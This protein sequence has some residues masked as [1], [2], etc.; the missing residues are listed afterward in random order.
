MDLKRLV[1]AAGVVLAGLSVTGFAGESGHAIPD[2]YTLAYHQDFEGPNP[3]S[4]FV[5]TDP[6]AWTVKETDGN[7][8]LALSAASDYKPPHRSPRNIALLAGYQFGSFVMEAQVQYTG[9]DYGHADQC[10]FFNVQDPAH[11]YYTHIGK[12]QDPHAHQIF[13]VD[14]KPRK[15]ITSQSHTTGFPWQQGRWEK[16]RVVRDAQQGRIAV[17]ID[18]MDQPILEADDTRFG[19]GWLGYGSFDD[20]G[21][22]DNIHIWAPKESIGRESATFF[23]GS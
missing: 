11:Y 21:R 5:F 23:E 16:V 18:D 4:D 3:L 6:S 19:M 17:Y 7:H 10:L 22:I 9:R 14:G 2:H 1:P 15:K 13:G 12:A 8:S 20:R